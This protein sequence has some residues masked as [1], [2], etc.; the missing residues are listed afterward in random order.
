MRYEDP[1]AEQQIKGKKE[2][3]IVDN[4]KERQDPLEFVVGNA[5]VVRGLDEGV[6]GLALYEK[7]E[8]IVSAKYSYGKRGAGKVIPPNTMV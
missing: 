7:C 5:E 3:I 4:S 8:I 2:W 6:V 1:E